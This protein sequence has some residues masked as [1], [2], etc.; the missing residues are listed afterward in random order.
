MS[1]KTR[2]GIPTSIA[3]DIF[4]Y[5][6]NWLILMN[7]E[8]TRRLRGKLYNLV[9]SIFTDESQRKSVK[10]LI[11][12]FTAD[13]HY[14]LNREIINFLKS[15]KIIQEGECVDPTNLDWEGGQPLGIN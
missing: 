9:D 7:E 14:E 6:N 2:V 5:S 1:K 11:K 3:D 12:D 8:G 15:K 4:G 10:G 13:V